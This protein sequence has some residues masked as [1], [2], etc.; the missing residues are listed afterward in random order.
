[1]D[2]FLLKKIT[3]FL[4]MPLTIILIALILA[5]LFH[6]SKPQLSFKYL[7]AGTLLLMISTF[8]PFSDW[9]MSPI[10]NNYPVFSRSSAPVDYIIVL[11]CSHSSDALLPE[12]TQLK[13]CSLQRLVEAIRIYRIHPEASLITSGSAFNQEF[14]NAE[15]VKRAAIS[16]GIPEEK[17]LTE[18]FPK[19]TEEEAQLIAPRVLGTNVVLVT[20]ADHM[21]RSM[22][23]FQQQGINPIAAPTGHWVKD[24]H[25]AK[26]WG[27]YTPTA[28]KLMQTT[29]AWY[30]TLGR[31]VQWLK[32]FF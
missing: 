10:E 30:E 21:P 8:A 1:M 14:S 27:Y 4:L 25:G 32:S 23:Y 5:L 11:G 16:L 26:D 3:S 24:N 13:T 20:N 2:L 12:T 31:I 29:T 15:T 22:T 28:K 9:V 17:I 19:D 18:N 7:C 6:R